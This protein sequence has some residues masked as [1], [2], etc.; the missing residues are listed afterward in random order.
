MKYHIRIYYKGGF[1]YLWHKDKNAW[2]K[3]TA[4]KYMNEWNARNPESPAELEEQDN[5]H[6]HQP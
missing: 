6:H 5:D 1:S 3:K 2:S 4:T